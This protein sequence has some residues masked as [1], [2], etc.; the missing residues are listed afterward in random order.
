MGTH[1]DTGGQADVEK[2]DV[3]AVQLRPLIAN[4]QHLLEALVR[5][6][7]EHDALKIQAQR[8]AEDREKL[9]QEMHDLQRDNES[10]RTKGDALWKEHQT[11]LGERNALAKERDTLL[12][13]RERI[14]A[15][16]SKFMHEVVQ[17]MNTPPR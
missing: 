2:Q 8:A 11:M 7:D 10:L 4:T 17:P 12:N 16:L 3:P 15:G 6:L 5:L 13:E 9:R 1:A 14:T